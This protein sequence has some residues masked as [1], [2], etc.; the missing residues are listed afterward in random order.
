MY[1]LD[2]IEESLYVILQGNEK[3]VSHLAADDDDGRVC[4]IT[5]RFI[6]SPFLFTVTFTL[7]PT[8]LCA[9]I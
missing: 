2:A 3:N 6:I 4:K 8:D 7:S 5:F 1:T 9:S